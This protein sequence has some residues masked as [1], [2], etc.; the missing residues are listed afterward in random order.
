MGRLSK[1]KPRWR[2]ICEADSGHYGAANKL[3]VRSED[4]ERG[5]C[6]WPWGSEVCKTYLALRGCFLSCSE[7]LGNLP[8]FL[9]RFTFLRQISFRTQCHFQSICD[10][11]GLVLRLAVDLIHLIINVPYINKMACDLLFYLLSRVSWLQCVG[12]ANPHARRE[13]LV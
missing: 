5:N 6:G 7:L 9:A 4:S 12:Y 2:S 11:L 3:T 13:L 8:V 1:E 10:Q